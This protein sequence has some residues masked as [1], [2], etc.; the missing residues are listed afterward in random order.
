VKSKEEKTISYIRTPCFDC[1]RK[2]LAQAGVLLLEYRKSDPAQYPLH[3][4]WAIGHLSEAEDELST[5]EPE[6]AKKIRIHRLLYQENKGYQIPIE[7]LLNE[8]TKVASI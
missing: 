4:W 3:P 5:V 1:V 8:V 7:I 2:H 6:L